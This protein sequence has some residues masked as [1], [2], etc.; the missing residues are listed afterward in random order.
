HD[1]SSGVDEIDK[2]VLRVQWNSDRTGFVVTEEKVDDETDSAG[3]S[4]TSTETTGETTGETSGEDNKEE[5]TAKVKPSDIEIVKVNNED[6]TLKELYLVRVED[7]NDIDSAPEEGAEMNSIQSSIK[8][9]LLE[10]KAVAELEEKVAAAGSKY[11][12]KG[13]KDKLI[14]KIIKEQ[15]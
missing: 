12:L 6:G 13:Q 8:A 14:N 10:D 2:Y 3:T 4:S 5:E 1:K 15:F 11:A 9:K 7:I